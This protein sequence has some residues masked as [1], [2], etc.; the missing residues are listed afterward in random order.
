VTAH[1][2]TAAVISAALFVAIPE[3]QYRLAW[4]VTRRPRSWHA[5]LWLGCATGGLVGCALEAQAGTADKAAGTGIASVVNAAVW[6]CLRR[7]KG[8]RRAAGLPGAKSRAL[9]D[10]IVKRARELAQ[11]RPVAVPGGARG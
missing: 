8:R 3:V 5:W 9:R 7:R 2:V 11:P 1:H 4:L 6:W 10:A